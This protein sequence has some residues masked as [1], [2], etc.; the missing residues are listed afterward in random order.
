[1]MHKKVG[2]KNAK[3]LCLEGQGQTDNKHRNT[4]I[5]T[6]DTER[7]MTSNIF[8]RDKTQTDKQT[9]INKYTQREDVRQDRQTNLSNTDKDM[10]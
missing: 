1:M 4:M 10:L 7:N 9:N 2:V 6:R 5:Q 8:K 3:R